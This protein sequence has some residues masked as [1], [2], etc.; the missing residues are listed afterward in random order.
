MDRPPRTPPTRNPAQDASG[1][2]HTT[3]LAPSPTGAL[4]LGNARSFVINWAL[5]RQR[6]WNVVLR[7][8]DLDTPRVKPGAIAQTIDLLNWLGLD[9]DQGPT[10]QSDDLTPYAHAMRSL[11]SRA[12][13]YPCELTRTQIEHAASAPNE[14]DSE[15]PFPRSLRPALAPL[16]FTDSGT[17]WRLAV[18]P[19]RVTFTDALAGPQSFDPSRDIGDFVIWTK[20]RCPAY[21]LAVVVDDAAQRVTQIVRG[22]DLLPSA[23]RQLVLARALGC[24]TEPTYTHL[25][26]VRG[27][28][29]RRLAKRHGDTRL[30]HYRDQG[31]LGDRT[32]LDEDKGMLFVF[33]NSTK[34]HFVMRDC[35][36]D[37]DI[38]YL[39][40][41][42]RIVAMHQMLV[43]EPQ[44]EGETELAYNNRLKRYSS[45]F[46]SQ[47]V[48][49]LAG[50][51]L[52]HLNLEDGQQIKLDTAR[53]RSL[54]K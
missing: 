29:G 17:N 36:I 50:G 18:E 15:T 37:I 54:A 53:L 48:I 6:A 20:R 12:L 1:G 45:R 4:H 52:D 10:I 32:H 27:N 8:E 33:P 16:P 30:T 9:W 7:I 28:D 13:A 14:G 31:G 24:D 19:G 2:I 38:I 21:Q 39:D 22:D 49:E 26:L 40:A 11:A 44:R 25:P 41:D 46:D 5:A 43:E 35:F 23:A 3:R 47:F 42:A 51:Q 34:R